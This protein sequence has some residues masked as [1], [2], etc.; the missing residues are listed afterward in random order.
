VRNYF[1]QRLLWIPILLFGI[2]LL[3]FVFINVAPGDPIMSMIDPSTLRDVPPEFIEARKEALGLNDP[4]PVRYVKWLGELA[5]GNLGFSYTR[6]RPVAE[7]LWGAWLNS[8]TLVV[9]SMVVSSVIGIVLGILSALRPYSLLDYLLTVVAFISPSTPS[10][11]ISMGLIYVGALKLGWFPTSGFHSRRGANA[12]G[13]AASPRLTRAGAVARR[14][15][16][17]A[18]LY[19]VKPAGSHPPRLHYDGA[20]QGVA[21]TPCHHAP[22][23]A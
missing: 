13:S 20:Q 15:R 17:V 5:Q 11:F 1:V 14:Y 22:C 3:D 4:I 18:A 10:F 9:I 2:T 23:V 16:H 21:R 19:A 8:I 7:L 6:Q 12:A